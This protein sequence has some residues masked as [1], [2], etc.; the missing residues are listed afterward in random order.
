VSEAG[1]AKDSGLPLGLLR[2]RSNL[3]LRVVSSLVLAPL[4]I[5]AAYVGGPVFLLFWLGAAAGVLCEWQILVCG[6]D[7]PTVLA[8]GLMTLAGAAVFIYFKSIGFALVFIALGI[9]A[10]ATLASR[11]HR[12]WCATGVLYA[13][14]MLMAPTLLRADASHGLLALLFLFAVVW[15]TDIVAYFGGRA[16]G[17]PK[18]APPISPNKTWS[19]AICGTAAAVA[20]GLAV[21]R[22]GGLGNLVAAS[23]LALVLS[24]A[25]QAGDLFESALKRR[26]AAKDAGNLLPGHGGLMDRLDGF[27]A[28]AV[29][30]VLV[31]IIHG[32]LDHPAGGLMVW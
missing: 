30:A 10:V 21:A 26:F 2:G 1:P 4:A 23:V 12:G 6:H 24:I 14:A 11:V 17:G 18:L 25:S 3:A 19:G 32:G 7:R 29:I 31:G 8:L 5:G 13:G 15:T 20:A 27:V 28:A 22:A 9:L 16:F